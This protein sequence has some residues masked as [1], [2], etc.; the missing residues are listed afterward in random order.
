MKA[1]QRWR[2]LREDDSYGHL[3]GMKHDQDDGDYLLAADAI[4]EIRYLLG[5]LGE[6]G[7][8]DARGGLEG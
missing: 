3:R 7:W 8:Q 6:Y 1:L 4:A 2:P 5:Q